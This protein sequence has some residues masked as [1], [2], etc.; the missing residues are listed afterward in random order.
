M[1]SHYS[2]DL[3]MAVIRQKMQQYDSKRREE[4]DRKLVNIDLNNSFKTKNWLCKCLMMFNEDG[5]ALKP[6]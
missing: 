1:L 6:C 5:N 4:E 3:R 2:S